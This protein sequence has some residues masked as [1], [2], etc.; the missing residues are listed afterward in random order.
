L[1]YSRT[2]LVTGLAII[3]SL[4]LGVL[5]LYPKYQQIGTMKTTIEDDRVRLNELQQ[6]N[7]RSSDLSTR[8]AELSSKLQQLSTR[9]F[10]P[11]TSLS[12]IT[13]LESLASDNGVQVEVSKFDPPVA[14]ATTGTLVYQAR[15]PLNNLVKFLTATENTPW[16]VNPTSVSLA[17]SGSGL[18]AGSADGSFATLSIEADTYWQ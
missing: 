2:N 6:L 18:A 7:Q 11:S 8:T 17:P 9:F 3:L 12:F 4:A 5:V 16:L 10:T 15:G 13:R 1:P 14:P